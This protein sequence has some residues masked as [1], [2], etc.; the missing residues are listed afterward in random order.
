MAGAAGSADRPDNMQDQVLC[1]HA[2]AQVA[3]DAY[4]HGLRL[5]EQ[6]GLRG[7]NMLD[8]AGADAERE[9]ADPAMAGG[10]AVAADNGRA[11]QRESQFRA[12]DMHDALVD[13]GRAEIAD[14]EFRGVSFQRRQLLGAFQIG[15]R[16]AFAIARRGARWSAD[17]D[18]ARPG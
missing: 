11:G 7:E 8:L 9:R 3:F 4:F 10:V 16:N 2:W 18:R 14:A 17:Y 12:D 1:G 13:V 5:L 6:Q 15:D